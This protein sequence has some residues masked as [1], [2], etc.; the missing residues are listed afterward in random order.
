MTD[1]F[2][3]LEKK[4]EQRKIIEAQEREEAL[5]KRELEQHRQKMKAE[6]K[7]RGMQM[8]GPKKTMQDLKVVDGPTF[9]LAKVIEK[10]KKEEKFG[11]EKRGV[12]ID[13]KDKE[14]RADLDEIKAS[15]DAREKAQKNFEETVK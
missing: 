5:E 14:V 9:S 13:P 11:L 3:K 2:D 1:F 4:N 10:V 7:A 15:K 12:N 6:F 8:N